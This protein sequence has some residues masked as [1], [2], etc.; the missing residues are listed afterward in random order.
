MTQKYKE[1][2]KRGRRLLFYAAKICPFL[3]LKGILYCYI[4]Q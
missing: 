1:D 4:G 2:D 3:S